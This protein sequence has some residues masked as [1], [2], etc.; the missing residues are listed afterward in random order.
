[1]DGLTELTVAVTDADGD[2]STLTASSSHTAIATVAVD[3]YTLTVTGQALGQATITVTAD[4]GTSAANA[5]TTF[6]VRVAPDTAWSGVSVGKEHS[7]GRQADGTLECWGDDAY[8]QVSATPTSADFV[9]VTAGG[10]RLRAA[11]R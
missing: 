5:T 8:D 11:G 1:M 7:C 2:E 4:D 6:G 10:S 9:S 3:A